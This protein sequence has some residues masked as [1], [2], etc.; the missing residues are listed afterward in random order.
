MLQEFGEAPKQAE[1]I[2]L[3]ST[4]LNI[5]LELTANQLLSEIRND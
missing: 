1:N 3:V 2:N 5:N 4:N